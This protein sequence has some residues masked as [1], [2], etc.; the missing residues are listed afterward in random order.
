MQNIIIYLLLLLIWLRVFWFV[1]ITEK[2]CISKLGNVEKLLQHS[3]H[4]AYAAQIS[5]TA[6]SKRW[7]RFIAKEKAVMWVL[8]ITRN[9]RFN[10]LH[11]L[12]QTIIKQIGYFSTII[13]KCG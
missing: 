10:L 3:Y 4:I 12:L 11:K 1:V 8:A 13:S 6:V 9:S 7:T 5:D 2:N